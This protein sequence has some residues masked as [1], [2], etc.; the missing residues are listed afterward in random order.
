MLKNLKIKVSGAV[1]KGYAMAATAGVALFPTSAFAANANFEAGVQGIFETIIDFGLIL[2]PLAATAMV[3][4]FGFMA[5]FSTDR[6]KK[7]DNKEHIKSTLAIA[8]L[9]MMAG[10]LVKWILGAIG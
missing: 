6:G 4:W 3:M 1:Q 10:G 7:S 8:A 5:K 2:C 9:I